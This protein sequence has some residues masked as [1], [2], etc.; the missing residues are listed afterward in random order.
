[1]RGRNWFISWY[2]T[3]FSFSKL[4]YLLDEILLFMT[5][6]FKNVFTMTTTPPW[7]MQKKFSSKTNFSNGLIPTP[8]GN[9]QGVMQ[10][11]SWIPFIAKDRVFTY[12]VSWWVPRKNFK[13]LHLYFAS[14][15]LPWSISNVIKCSHFPRKI[16]S[17]HKENKDIEL[18]YQEFI[19]MIL[20]FQW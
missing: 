2:T 12:I 9:K 14:N 4:D 18:L 13:I 19:M 16:W 6:L 11:L 1:M 5:Y 10:P 15:G 8:C 17:C 7:F 20:F 3:A